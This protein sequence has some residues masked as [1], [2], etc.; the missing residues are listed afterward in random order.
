[1]EVTEE[2]PE[3]VPGRPKCDGSV[4]TGAADSVL[5]LE[6]FPLAFSVRGL[7]LTPT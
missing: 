7:P 1:M 6:T 2:L 3:T 5:R 4:N